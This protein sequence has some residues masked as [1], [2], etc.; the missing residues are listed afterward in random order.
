MISL[1]VATAKA[2]IK[3]AS[4]DK[5][6]PN[7]QGIGIIDNGLAATDGFCAVE[8]Y[9]PTKD[10]ELVGRVIDRKM[11][12]TSMKLAAVTKTYM[13]VNK[14]SLLEEQLV[15]PSLSAITPSDDFPLLMSANDV[16]TRY[17]SDAIK[18]SA[19]YLSLLGLVA[20][21]CE[22][23]V[24]S[25]SSVKSGQPLRFDVTGDKQ[26]AIVLINHL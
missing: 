19:G 20:V 2:L 16:C 7:I 6:R 15:F 18:V 26:S 14:S 10:P 25:L 1:S 12:E 17:M 9:L 21:A 4:N 24:V 5:T 23:E 3:F 13:V 11:F 8:F 22:T